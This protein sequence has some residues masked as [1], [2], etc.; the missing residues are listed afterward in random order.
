MSA[1]LQ[2]RSCGLLEMSKAESESYNPMI[3]S[4]FPHVTY[5]HRTVGEFLES[6]DVTT[7]M[8]R[9]TS[10]GY[11]VHHSLMSACLS[12]IKI[13]ASSRTE[14]LME[15]RAVTLLLFYQ[16]CPPQVRAGLNRYITAFDSVLTHYVQKGGQ[17]RT[18][19]FDENTHWSA[20]ET[21]LQTIRGSDGWFL[22]SIEGIVP[23]T[24]PS[25][26]TLAARLGFTQYLEC[27][28]GLRLNDP[29]IM[30]YALH[31]WYNVADDARSNETGRRDPLRVP[32]RDRRDTVLFLFGKLAKH[33]SR[34]LERGIFQLAQPYHNIRHHPLDTSVL[35]ACLVCGLTYTDIW[36]QQY[37]AM[38]IQGVINTLKGDEDMENQRLAIRMS[39]VVAEQSR[40]S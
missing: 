19:T 38:E 11:D 34:H 32:L 36:A 13:S 3:S 27:E 24:S 26:L 1:R 7:E 35:I 10:P 21:T 18:N 25:I 6:E 5:L 16:S 31:A 20:L 22:A 14:D 40:G 17:P 33:N 23:R 37:S 9:M 30:C 2:S 29:L 39:K 12:M 8:Q 4:H 28:D 15:D